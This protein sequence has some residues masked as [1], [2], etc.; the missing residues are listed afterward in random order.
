MPFRNELDTALNA[1]ITAMRICMC[2]EKNLQSISAIEKED[3]SPV[4]I[5]DFANQAIINM[6]IKE[7]FPSDVIVAEES[8]E[9][10]RDNLEIISRILELLEEVG[11]ASTLDQ[12]IA[13]INS[14][15]G[16]VGHKGRFWVLDPIDGTKG[17]L[18]G[19]QY[20]IALSLVVNEKVMMG[21]LGCPHLPVAFDRP[22]SEIGCILYSTRGKGTWMRNI[23][24]NTDL[25][26]AVDSTMD[27]KKARFCESFDKMHSPHEL[28][29]K[30]ASFL[31]IT[32][33]P[34]RMDSQVK[35][36]AVARGDASIYLRLPRDKA[37]QEKIWD[38]SAGSII[39]E[40][41]GGKVTDINGKNLNYSTG[42]TLRKNKGILVTNGYLHQ[43]VLE[44][45]AHCI[46]Q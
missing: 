7:M 23:K 26:V 4:T 45:I 38:H 34:L 17:F 42:R 12:V 44:A 29:Q 31:G 2:V 5:A 27:C 8:A 11:L 9:N 18:R 16:E 13:S 21:V 19:D 39:V 3:H 30:I 41:S 1:V 10:L 33:A 46:S 37:Y 36:A 35:Y 14:G 28:H 15:M 20:A 24:Q 40:E 32:S 43:K 22:D 25:P 6:L